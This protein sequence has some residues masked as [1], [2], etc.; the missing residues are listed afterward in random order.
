LV[1]ET[2]NAA[3]RYGLPVG[4][5]FD[6][7]RIIAQRIAVVR[8]RLESERESLR[9][10]EVDELCRELARIE[11][12]LEVL[13]GL[14]RGPFSRVRALRQPKIGRLRQYEPRPLRVPATYTRQ[15]PPSPAPTISIVTPSY[16]QGRFLE[17]TILSVLNQGYPSL[18]YVVQ[19]GGSTDE[20]LELL[21][22]LTG[23]KVEWNSEPDSGQAD[24]INRGFA[25]TDGPIMAWLNSDDLLLPGALTCVAAYFA[26]NPGI[27]VVYGNRLMIDEEDHEIGVWVL[28]SHDDS[29]LTLVDFIPQETLFWRRSIWE[30]SGAEV[31]ADFGYALDW[32]LLLRFR[33]AGARFARIPRFLG[34]FRVHAEQKT[35]AAGDL[36]L[37]ETARLRERTHGRPVSVAEAARRMRPYTLR[38]LAEHTRFRLE[39]GREKDWVD[40]PRLLFNRD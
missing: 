9:P 21:R 3:R 7:E 16:Q 38:H 40:V 25:R 35:T 23:T 17:R 24:A 34:A 5:G 18:Q 8:R 26:R 12:S 28:P 32:D 4:G 27:D 22:G 19:D 1:A 30:A 29:A 15:V 6:S 37:A 2:E 13:S 36:G 11:A 10:E 14:I 20:T 33:A 31:D 39:R